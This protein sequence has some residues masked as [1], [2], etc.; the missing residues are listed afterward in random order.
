MF[1]KKIKKK[2]KNWIFIESA[3]RHLDE[4]KRTITNE[5]EQQRSRYDALTSEFDRLNLEYENANKT[6]ATH[7][8]TLRE[9]KQQRDE[10]RWKKKFFKF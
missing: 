3:L 7:E 8:Q 5:L 4:I 6:V 9:I 2:N 1:N 10:Y